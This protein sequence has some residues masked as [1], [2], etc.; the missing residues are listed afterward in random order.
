[1]SKAKSRTVP[2]YHS[3]TT[4]DAAV[5]G[6]VRPE[7]ASTDVPPG[8]RKPGASQPKP[9][10]S[11]ARIRVSTADFVAALERDEVESRR[12]Q[13]AAGEL[14]RS[15][16]FRARLQISPQ[17][18]SGAVRATRMYAL[19]GPSGEALYPAFFTEPSPG[20]LVLEHVCR[21]LGAL[22]G[23]SKHFFFTSKRFSL[24]SMNPLQALA[25]GKF[26]QVLAAAQAFRD[27]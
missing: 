14:L 25:K 5:S 22:P 3:S 20:R 6:K 11:A 27:E 12:E 26:A 7:L 9:P 19:Q 24:G 23:G 16:E 2:Q 4:V 17:A 10:I 18:L 8:T 21:A 13:L 1:M 15:A